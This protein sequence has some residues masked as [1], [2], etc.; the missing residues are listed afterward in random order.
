MYNTARR[1]RIYPTKSQEKI[2]FRMTEAARRLWNDAL[3]HR[4]R[5]WENERRSVTYSEQAW[6]LTGERQVDLELGLLYSQSAQDILRRLDK[7]VKAYFNGLSEYPRFKPANIGSSFTY[8]QAYNGSVN[9]NEKTIGLSKVGTVPVVVH[10]EAPPNSRLKTCTVI[11]EM[12]DNWYVSLAYE[13]DASIPKA[14][15]ISSPVGV[16]LGLKSLVA[17]TDGVKIPHPN[18]LRR[19]ERRL[20]RLQRSVSRKQKG[21]KN[22][23]KARHLLAACYAKTARQRKDFNHKLTTNLVRRHDA[24]FFEDLRIANMS[25]NHSLAKSIQDAGWGQILSFAKYKEG[26]AGGVFETVQS[27]YSTQECVFCGTLNPV[28]LSIREFDCIGCGRRLDRDLNAAWIVLKRGIAKVGQDMPKL[29]PVEIRP[30][31]SELISGACPVDE[32]GTTCGGIHARGTPPLESHDSGRGRMS[33]TDPAVPAPD[34]LYC[35]MI[36][37]TSQDSGYHFLVIA[38]GPLQR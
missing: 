4:R 8:P 34:L 29:T 1:Y 20:V 23:T 12:S 9:I 31:P 22:R 6:I 10:R 26:R 17:T 35:P 36:D 3:E 7:A 13:V 28:T 37:Q 33:L 25:K 30:P 5:V 21:S 15:T 32:A 11:H 14:V 16:D 24:I 38:E 2:L 19:T 27:A 18:F